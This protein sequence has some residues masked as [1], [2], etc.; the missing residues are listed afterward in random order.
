[1]KRCVQ[2][3]EWPLVFLEA[4]NGRRFRVLQGAE[5]GGF[6]GACRSSHSVCVCVRAPQPPHTVSSLQRLPSSQLWDGAPRVPSDPPWI[7]LSLLIPP[8]AP[9]PLSRFPS[10]YLH[11]LNPRESSALL[12]GNSSPW[13]VPQNAINWFTV[14][15]APFLLR[16]DRGMYALGTPGRQF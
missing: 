2:N 8:T 12:S 11:F 5:G 6:R 7:P 10:E 13:F 9:A 16:N 1:M 14:S 4:P 15:L 3:S